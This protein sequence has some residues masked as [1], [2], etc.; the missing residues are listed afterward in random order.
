MIYLHA[1]FVPANRHDYVFMHIYNIENGKS[2][3]YVYG[4]R[5][6]GKY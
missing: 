1:H 6:V 2:L 5:V 4:K 3:D